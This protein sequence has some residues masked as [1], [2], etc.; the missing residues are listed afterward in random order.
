MIAI[1]RTADADRD[2]LIEENLGIVW[3]MA[4]RIGRSSTT[5]LQDLVQTAVV[6]LV[7]NFAQYDP[8]RG[9]F[10][11]WAG[12]VAW[13]AMLRH[14]DQYSSAIT[15]PSWR[16]NISPEIQEQRARAM[17]PQS[18]DLRSQTNERDHLGDNLP[19]R[20]ATNLDDF[21]DGQEMLA[22][23][24]ITELERTVLAMRL[25][26]YKLADVGERLGRSKEWARQIE[27]RALDNLRE[28]FTP[29][30]ETA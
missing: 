28:R 29:Q 9:K 12:K 18:L 15:V 4:T 25:R 2:R 24:A 23:D 30:P 17:R 5:D 3:T 11:T 19:A 10:D 13:H 27:Q 14:N 20:A 22:S 7:E 8:T 26:G 6:K 16:P 1:E 21:L